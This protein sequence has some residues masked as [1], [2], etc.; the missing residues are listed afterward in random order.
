MISM[1]N[2]CHHIHS[3]GM[4]SMNINLAHLP[5][6]GTVLDQPAKLM[7]L[8]DIIRTEMYKDQEARLKRGK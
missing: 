8:F 2:A 7:E 4:G 1:F 3:G 6:E 5:Y